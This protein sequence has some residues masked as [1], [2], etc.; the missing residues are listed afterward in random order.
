MQALLLPNQ[1]KQNNWLKILPS[2][3]VV[4]LETTFFPL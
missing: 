4:H 2:F 3:Y 1:K